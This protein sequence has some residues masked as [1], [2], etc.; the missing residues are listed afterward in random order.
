MKKILPFLILGFLLGIS[1]NAQSQYEKG[2]NEAFTLLENNQYMEAGNL[3][4]RIAKAE[5]E[6][7][8]PYYYASQIKIIASFSNNNSVKKEQQL[9]EAQ[10]LLD[11]A[12]N[13]GGRENA[14]IMVLQAMLH[15][16][17]LT[18]DP[19]LYGMKLSPVINRIY[20]DAFE[21]AP[22]NPRVI[23]SKAEW[24]INSARF[25]GEDPEKYCEDLQN[26]LRLFGKEK[27]PE[28][29]YPSWGEDRARKLVAATCKK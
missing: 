14:E 9:E 12:R 4:E 8:L 17:R 19:N 29:F 16:S 28:K 25:F 24:D 20:N 2:M 10:N 21:K 13:F 7:W 23:V 5:K 27:A 18:I 3:F 22:N 15:T 6:N 11:Q 26:G 1:A